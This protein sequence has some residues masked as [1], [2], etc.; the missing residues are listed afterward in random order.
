MTAE[1]SRVK[2]L[3]TALTF[4]GRLNIS[5]L[6]LIS[7]SSISVIIIMFASCFLP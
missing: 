1:K 7:S 5:H 4:D 6:L 2:A 3:R